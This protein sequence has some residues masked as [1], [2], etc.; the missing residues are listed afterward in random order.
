M[1]S[2]WIKRASRASLFLSLLAATSVFAAH[3]L[4][5][6]DA[7]ADT[8]PISQ[9]LSARARTAQ[10]ASG[11][12][13]VQ[14]HERFDVPTF[15]WFARGA[16][17]NVMQTQSVQ[18]S[19]SAARAYLFEN[20]SALGLEFGDAANATVAGIHDT[21]RGAIIVKFQE[22]IDGIEVFRET[23]NVAMT[24]DRRLIATSGFLAPSR[25]APLRPAD[26]SALATVGRSQSLFPMSPEAALAAALRDLAPEAG[27]ID[28]G[29]LARHPAAAG[30]LLL[31]GSRPLQNGVLLRPAHV[32]QVWFHLPDRLQAAYQVT[33][34]VANATTSDSD[35][36]TYVISAADGRVLFRH[37]L[38]AEA[39]PTPVTYRVWAA[40]DGN[41]RP[42]DGPQGFAGFPHPTGTNDGYQAPFT[43]SNLISLAYGPISTH[44]R[45]LPENATATTGNNVDAYADL[46]TP[47]GFSAGD[48]RASTSSAN[49]FDYAYDV[50]GQ[51]TS[52]TTQRMASITQLFYTINFLHDWYY[53]SG[54][55]EAAGNAQDDN[56]GRGGIGGDRLR[57]EAQDFSGRNNANMSTPPD[58]LSPRMQMY[59]FDGSPARSIQMDAPLGLVGTF[60]VGL[61]TFGPQQFDLTGTV[62]RS[63]PANGCSA[64]SSAVAGNIAFIDRGDCN[65]TD[66]AKNAQAAGAIGVIIGNLATSPSPNNFTV[67]GCPADPCTADEINLIPS[68]MIQSSIASAFRTQLAKGPAHG[69]MKR[70]AQTDR[71]GALDTFV[72]AHEWTHYQSG[73]LI[74]DSNGLNGNQSGG[75]NEGWSDF[76][77]LLLLA[78][79]E[80]ASVPSNATFN[81]VYASGSYVLSGGVNGVG[82][83]S[84]YYYGIRRVPYST[85]M[86][87]D[88]LTYE[89][90]ARGVRISGLLRF[91][92]DGSSNDEVHNTGEVATPD[93]GLHG[94]IEA[95]HADRSD[96]PRR[97]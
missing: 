7:V 24:R 3:R 45:W 79:P 55:N 80:D 95:P 43:S 42:Y 15:V 16:S 78:R 68:M 34:D 19:E 9:A 49:T 66:K 37:N 81:G 47:D 92:F 73:R 29:S 1:S 22:R 62:V 18:T 75:M 65:F 27:P 5:N 87:I 60:G 30:G 21:H 10:A 56:F 32:K 20:A 46:V 50:T 36:Y 12:V 67:M 53:D 97:A 8:P 82:I 83:N 11:G 39:E 35:M 52:S 84:A 51:P 33:L 91:G 2:L 94:G 88:P 17:P 4:P 72:V 76:G 85:D 26:L 58:G 6:F 96:F 61:A 71:D 70:E 31:D 54:F 25:L 44:D 28:E 48:V 64:I 86:I 59:L 74:G 41:H 23:L 77:A 93:E 69:T 63:T 90:I 14:W 89:H 13:P 40:A 38:T 57:G